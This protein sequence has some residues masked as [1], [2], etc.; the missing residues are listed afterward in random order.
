MHTV[1]DDIYRDF[2][3]VCYKTDGTLDTTFGTNGKVT[4]DFFND[5]DEAD[6]MVMQS[7]GRAVLVG[8]AR[9]GETQLAMAGYFISD[10]QNNAKPVIESVTI[11]KKQLIV[12]GQNFESPSLI[13]LNGEKQKKS[14]NDETDPTAVVIGLKAGTL[15]AP[16]ATITVQ[17]KN[18]ESGQISDDFVFTRPLE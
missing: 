10:P 5:R 16:G 6:G 13:Y 14:V 9:N 12:T 11:K 7:N 2:A 8:R 17:V 4:T 18:T 3:L 15:I 1:S